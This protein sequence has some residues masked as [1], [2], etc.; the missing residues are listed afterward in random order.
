M[1][2]YQLYVRLHEC[3][4]WSYGDTYQDASTA[5]QAQLLARHRGFQCRVITP[6]AKARVTELAIAND[7][8]ID[9]TGMVIS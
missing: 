6:A 9:T 5:W 3:D 7:A 4:Q 1:K 2:Q 8:L